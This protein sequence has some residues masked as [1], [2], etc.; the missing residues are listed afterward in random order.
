MNTRLAR[1]TYVESKRRLLISMTL[2]RGL[3][4]RLSLPPDHGI[5]GNTWTVILKEVL[6]TLPDS[7]IELLREYGLDCPP[8]HFS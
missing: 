6:A 8:D 7:V 1:R 5:L 4:V 2:K 3:L